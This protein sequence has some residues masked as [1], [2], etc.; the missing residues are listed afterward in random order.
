MKI[1]VTTF[2]GNKITLDVEPTYTVEKLK[3]LIY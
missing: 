1:F 2:T 3:E